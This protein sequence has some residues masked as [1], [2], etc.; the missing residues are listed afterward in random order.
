MKA[1]RIYLTINSVVA[2]LSGLA[3]ILF[4]KALTAS[5]VDVIPP[6]GLIFVKTVGGLILCIG[7]LD[8]YARN[9]KDGKMM[10]GVLLTN[11]FLH[12]ISVSFDISAIFQGIVNS[13]SEWY[14]IGF[15]SLL[16]LGFLYF[17]FKNPLQK[18]KI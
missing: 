2:A 9:L 12:A 3:F 8:W 18:Q 15:R 5:Q 4:P 14:N 10:E 11:F 13:S 16:A 1:L 6:G 17:V 7:L